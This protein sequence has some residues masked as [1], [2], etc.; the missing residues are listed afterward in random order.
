MDDGLARL[1]ALCTPAG[2]QGG[3]LIG[4]FLAG[5]AGSAM[6][7]VPMCGGFVLGQVSTRLQR[8]P[9]ARL[10]E[11]QRLQTGLLLPYHLGRLSTYALLGAAAAAS[12]TLAARASWLSRLSS[13][14]LVLAAGLFLVQAVSRL[15]PA[16]WGIGPAIAPRFMSRMIARL[17]QGLDR[18]RPVNGYLLGLALGLLPCGFV[19]SALIAAAASAGPAHGALTMLAFGLGTMP[20]LMIVGVAGHAAG[21]R[22]RAFS[23]AVA[24]PV[25][26]VNALLLLSVALRPLVGV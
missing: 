7:C 3:L 2:A 6:H 5:A 23:E 17:T 16:G 15:L 10:C 8:V 4:L 18:S 12:A 13:V 20:A 21:S 26:V 1:W 11:R 22:W 19:Y 25:L 24:G 9:L 14:L